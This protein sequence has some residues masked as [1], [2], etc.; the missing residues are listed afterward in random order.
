LILLGAT[1]EAEPLLAD[2][3]RRA[4][5][6]AGKSH[7]ISLLI[8]HRLARACDDRGDLAKAPH[9]HWRCGEASSPATTATLPTPL[10]SSDV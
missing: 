5:T 2:T 1:N 7:P 3:L 10:C 8:K 9:R 6:V 4:E